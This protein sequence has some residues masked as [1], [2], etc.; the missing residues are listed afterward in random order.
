MTEKKNQHYLP[1]FYLRN[2]SYYN[3]EKQ[4]GLYNIFNSFFIHQAKL[5]TQGSK[6]FYY[7]KDGIIENFL[8][9]HEGRFA[10]IV[11]ETAQECNLPYYEYKTMRSAVIAHFKHLK[12]L[13]QEPQM[14]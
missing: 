7:G 9:E 14:A 8:S 4:I 5:K 13:G 6:N 11:K 3:N 10:K 2:F 1:K 12:E